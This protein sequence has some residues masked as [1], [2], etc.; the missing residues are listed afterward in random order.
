MQFFWSHPLV[1]KYLCKS[2]NLNEYISGEKS[3]NL[4]SMYKIDIPI[5][6][7]DKGYLWAALMGV[8]LGLSLSFNIGKYGR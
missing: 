8:F 7:K 1:T 5:Q 6:K 4:F 3:R 2:T